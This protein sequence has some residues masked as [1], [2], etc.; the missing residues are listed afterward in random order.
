MTRFLFRF[1]KIEHHFTNL[2]DIY[3]YKTFNANKITIENNVIK[4]D[5][6]K[7]ET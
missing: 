5:I 4:L 7:A 2:K 3:N 6:D 1:R